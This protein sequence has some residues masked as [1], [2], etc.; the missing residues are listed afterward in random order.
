MTTEI[1]LT[2]PP[3]THEIMDAFVAP[4]P[5]RKPG[6]PH[7]V[8]Q[9]SAAAAAAFGKELM[10][11][12][13]ESIISMS[14]VLD[15]VRAERDAQN[16]KWGEQNLA[17]GLA[18]SA[19]SNLLTGSADPEAMRVRYE[20]QANHWKAVNT[21]RAKDRRIGWDGILLEEALEALAESDPT[22]A[23]AELVQVAAVAVAMIE[24]IDRAVQ[25]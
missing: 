20:T 3:D 14:R 12:E 19:G 8:Q 17:L 21:Q 24:S 25:V 2:P 16:T 1:D 23:R 9:P 15:E 18:S 7:K 5:K 6:R 10:P 13:S 4:T 11:D 22:K